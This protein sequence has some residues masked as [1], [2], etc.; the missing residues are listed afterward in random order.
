MS[1]TDLGIFW[2]LLDN[3]LFFP[4]I[5]GFANIT[6]GNIGMANPLSCLKKKKILEL[7]EVKGHSHICQQKHIISLLR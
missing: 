3:L 1:I 4:Q 6:F 7:V 5:T 2:E